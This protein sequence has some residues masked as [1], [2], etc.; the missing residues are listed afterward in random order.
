MNH[1]IL[2]SRVVFMLC[3]HVVCSNLM[4]SKGTFRFLSHN[5]VQLNA[6]YSRLCSKAKTQAK[7]QFMKLRSSSLLT[8]LRKKGLVHVSEEEADDV[9]IAPM[10]T[11]PG[12]DS[13][14]LTSSPARLIFSPSSAIHVCG[15]PINNVV[16]YMIQQ[17]NSR[18]I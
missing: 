8:R 10:N 2:L 6:S 3:M 13:Q 4:F 1:N 7:R 11:T 12:D 16:V 5:P 18:K 15:S 14:P 17:A 9:T